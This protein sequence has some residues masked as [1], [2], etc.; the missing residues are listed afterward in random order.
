MYVLKLPPCTS[1]ELLI[2][3]VI[4]WF[5]SVYV[6]EVCFMYVLKLPPIHTC[7]LQFNV[8]SIGV[9][10]FMYVLKLPPCTYWSVLS[11]TY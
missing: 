11:C 1:L 9:C 10:S 3:Y 8:T 2:M 7:K 4:E 6:H 5:H